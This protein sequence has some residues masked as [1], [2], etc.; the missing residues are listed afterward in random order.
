MQPLS[1]KIMKYCW[2]CNY[3]N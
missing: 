2:N 1:T 3:C